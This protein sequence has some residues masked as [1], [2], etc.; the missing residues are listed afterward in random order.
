MNPIVCIHA[1]QTFPSLFTDLNHHQHTILTSL[2][3]FD[4]GEKSPALVMA[5]ILVKINPSLYFHIFKIFWA[6]HYVICREKSQGHPELNEGL[7]AKLFTNLLLLEKL[8]KI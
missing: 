5:L 4:G 7:L 3:D 8:Q 6:V 1:W 2:K